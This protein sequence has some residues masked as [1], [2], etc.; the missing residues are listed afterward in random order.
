MGVVLAE[1]R[2]IARLSPAEWGNFFSGHGSLVIQTP[3]DL[4]CIPLSELQLVAGPGIQSQMLMK[5]ASVPIR[6]WPPT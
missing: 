1:A 5:I 6:W 3:G 2:L 4:K